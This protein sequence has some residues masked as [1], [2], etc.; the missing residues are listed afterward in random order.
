MKEIKFRNLSR[1]IMTLYEE[2]WQTEI[3][4]RV[5]KE[6]SEKAIECSNEIKKAFEEKQ[7]EIS[8]G[9][10]AVVFDYILR[11][12]GRYC[13]IKN[14]EDYSGNKYDAMIDLALHTVFFDRI[15]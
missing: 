11:N 1:S 7:R 14:V 12:T 9:N 3:M 5:S 4:E 2:K 10:F 8:E 15:D 13:W 6:Y